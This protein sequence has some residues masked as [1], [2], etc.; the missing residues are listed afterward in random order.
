MTSYSHTG[1][2][3]LGK[4]NP[5]RLWYHNRAR[6]VSPLPQ[7]KCERFTVDTNSWAVRTV[8]KRLWWNYSARGVLHYN[9]NARC[10]WYYI[11][12]RRVRRC[13]NTYD[14]TIVRGGF[15]ITKKR[16]ALM[17]S[18]SHAGDALLIRVAWKTSPGRLWYRHRTRGVDHLPKTSAGGSPLTPIHE[19]YSGWTPHLAWTRGVHR[20]RQSFWSSHIIA[21]INYKF[22]KTGKAHMPIQNWY[23]N[24]ID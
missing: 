10:V 15:S 19:S 24:T 21:A 20:W 16:E 14:T 2:A 6:G 11:R 9:P 1:G 5:E 3:P 18:Y 22:D 4:T 23:F 8:L 7:N 13:W 17:I 12:A